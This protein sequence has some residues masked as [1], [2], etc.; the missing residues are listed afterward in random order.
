M[1]FVGVATLVVA[2]VA[3]GGA[4]F[5]SADTTPTKLDPAYVARDSSGAEALSVQLQLDVRNTGSFDFSVSG[6][7]DWVGV[8]PIG[9]VSS[10]ISHVKGEVAAKFQAAGTST[11]SRATVRMEGEFD[12][13]HNRATVN[14]W[15]TKP[16]SASTTHYLI[17][18]GESSTGDAPSIARSAL[19]ALVSQ[20]WPAVYQVA[21][22]AITTRYTEAQF[23]QGMSSQSQPAMSDATFVGEGAIS[24]MSG[25][26]YFTQPITFTSTAAN[27]P[28]G[29]TADLSLISE[30][31][32]WKFAGTTAP[33]PAS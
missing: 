10:H 3:V 31:G 30:Q 9:P 19:T 16:G 17:H 12:Q 28:V 22:S 7:G 27:G 6:V 4:A 25:I 23:V 5:A 2:A 13:S 1:T 8:I 14:L 33:Q 21:A 18:S 32:T 20:N 26:S 11:V 15:V 24:V 29:Y